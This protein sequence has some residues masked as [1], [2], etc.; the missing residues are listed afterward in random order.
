MIYIQMPPED[1]DD[2]ALDAEFPLGDGTAD[3][4]ALVQCP[5]CGE[6][7]EM[8]LDPGSGPRQE[9]VEDCQVCCR[10]WQVG[11]RYGPDGAAHVTLDASDDAWDD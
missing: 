2:E 11:V 7:M 1:A 8:A 10:P 5:Y 9:Y 6:G 4:A 3:T